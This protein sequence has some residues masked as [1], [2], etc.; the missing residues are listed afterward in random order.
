VPKTIRIALNQQSIDRAIHELEIYRSALER[1]LSTLI[2]RLADIGLTVASAGYQGAIYDGTNDVSVSI[3]D[4][5]ALKKAVVAVGSAVLF[6]EF[7]TGVFY[8]DNYPGEKPAGIS[9][10]GGYGNGRGKQNTWGYYGDPG[11]NG[12]EITKP[13]GKTVV[14]TH[15]NPSN[16][17]MYNSTLAMNKQLQR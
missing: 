10:R 13:N 11:T 1:K 4:G 8:A 16:P 9:E 5:G 2:Q 3:E 17:V 12:V 6:I 7:G 15:G 14:L